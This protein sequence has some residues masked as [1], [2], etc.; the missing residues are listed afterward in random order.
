MLER[1]RP[2]RCLVARFGGGAPALQWAASLPTDASAV[3]VLGDAPFTAGDLPLIR[4]FAR[5]YLG[6]TGA[7]AVRCG[8]SLRDARTVP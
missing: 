1:Q 4:A 3:F 2:D 7:T 5:R 6:H 8:G